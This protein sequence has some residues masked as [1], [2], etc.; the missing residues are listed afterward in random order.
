M[1]KRTEVL[2]IVWILLCLAVLVSSYWFDSDVRRHGER[3]E[4]ALLVL[5]MSWLCFP[6][7]LLS[8]AALIGGLSV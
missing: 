3:E 1:L 6:L 8:P 7:C 5:G 2:K 4:L